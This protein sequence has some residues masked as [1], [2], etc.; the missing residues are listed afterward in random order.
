M[1]WDYF[2]IGWDHI[3]N[4]NAWDHLLF[5]M[6]L[7]AIYVFK[8]WKQVLILVTAFTIGHTVT[9]I[10]ATFNI[11]RFSSTWIEFLIPVTIMITALANTLMKKFTPKTIRLNYFLALAFGLIH[12]MGFANGLRSLLGKESDILLPLLG[13]NLGLEAGQLVAVLALLILA[14]IWQ[15]VFKV[16]RRDWV[17][18]LS[19][20][21]FMA[22]LVM[23]MERLPFNL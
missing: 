19:G 10:L 23:A 18:F 2:H 6:A 7:S 4:R 16:S 8:D 5:I 22:A 9:L 14:A 3:I 12:G 11:I 13:F 20:G 17:L 1:F 21:A 15:G